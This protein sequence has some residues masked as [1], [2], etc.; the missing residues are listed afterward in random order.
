MSFLKFKGIKTAVFFKPL[1]LHPLYKKYN[2]DIKNS[3]KVWKE[4]VTVPTF[5]KMTDKQLYF[6]IK[7]LKEFDNKIQKHENL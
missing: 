2:F 7:C 6:V 5:P 4:F 1:P 3:L